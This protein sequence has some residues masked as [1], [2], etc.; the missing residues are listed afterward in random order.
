MRNLVIPVAIITL[1]LATGGFIVKNRIT[2]PKSANQILGESQE[3][4]TQ[5]SP[6]P[7]PTQTISTTLNDGDKKQESPYSIEIKSPPTYNS[8]GFTYTATLKNFLVRPYITNF[9]FFECNFKDENE[10]KYSGMIADQYSFDK[11]VFPNESKEFT[12]KDVNVNISGLEHTTA[13]LRKCSYNE[14]GENVCK[15]INELRIID[16]TGYISTD[17][18]GAGGGYGGNG[19]Q[20]PVNI[21]FPSP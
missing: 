21:T 20:F 16:C 6:T 13:G 12:V 19:G 4:V 7:T 2:N 5:P 15:P 1:V 8:Y 18:K 3:Q 17:G 10:N 9:G 14:K 11:A